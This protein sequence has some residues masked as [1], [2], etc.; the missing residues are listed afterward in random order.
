MR[1][2]RVTGSVVANAPGGAVRIAVTLDDG[3]T[4]VTVREVE[5][6]LMSAPDGTGLDDV[7]WTTDQYTQ[8][9]IANELAVA[10]W[11]VIGEERDTAGQGAPGSATPVYVV[12][13]V[14]ESTP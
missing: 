4:V 2:A 7:A 10:G 5:A 1:F 12:R 8:E 13:L 3:R 9:T 11:E 6:S 14:G